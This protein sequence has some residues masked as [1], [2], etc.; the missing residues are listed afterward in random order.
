M[1][2]EQPILL[3]KHASKKFKRQSEQIEYGFGSE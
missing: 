2:S 1:K 3:Q